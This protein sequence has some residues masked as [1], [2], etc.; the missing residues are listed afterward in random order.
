MIDESLLPTIAGLAIGIGLVSVLSLMIGSLNQE[1]RLFRGEFGSLTSTCPEGVDV[2]S[3]S[4]ECL[5]AGVPNMMLLVGDT[6]Y[7][8]DK[9]SFCTEQGCVD[10]IFIVPDGRIQ[11][12][13]GSQI[14]FAP[15]GIKQ[16]TQLGI[17]IYK[18]ENQLTDLKL[19]P[20]RYVDTFEVDLEK[21]EYIFFVGAHWMK[22]EFSEISATYYF[23][24]SVQ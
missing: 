13:Q 14:T 7:G 18:G 3:R 1:R 6:G 17:S 19:T 22:G 20:T 23:N 21:G 2:A 8:G 5:F 16:P 10:T 15:S 9:G 12:Q 11:V 24:V 4:Q